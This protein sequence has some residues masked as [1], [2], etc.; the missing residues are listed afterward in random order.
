MTDG[1]VYEINE[2]QVFSRDGVVYLALFLLCL[3]GLKTLPSL[4]PGS[5]LRKLDARNCDIQT[6]PHNLFHYNLEDVYLTNNKGESRG[7]KRR[8]EA[9]A[10][11]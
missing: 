3:I 6:V 11:E 5:P 7:V 9:G 4:V 2:K 8:K 10:G 1:I